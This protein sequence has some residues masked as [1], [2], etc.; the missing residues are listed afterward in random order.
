MNSELTIRPARESDFD[1]LYSMLC[2]L[3]D[4]VLDREA[5][6]ET[7]KLNLSN[8]NIRYL[9]AEWERKPIGMASCHIQSL[10][11]HAAKIGEIQEMYV[12]PNWR[13]RGIGSTLIE[14]LT[15]YCLE[16]GVAQM[17]VTTNRTR[18]DTHR[19]YERESFKNSHIKLVRHLSVNKKA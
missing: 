5:F 3:E 6:S 14:H 8:E 16:K 11:H 1:T 13:S 9:I 18:L 2:E 15:Q 4:L 7:F 19:F 12:D 17:E 10:L